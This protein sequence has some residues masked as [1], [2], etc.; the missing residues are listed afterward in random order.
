MGAALNLGLPQIG[1]GGAP[2]AGLYEAVSEEQAQAALEAAWDG[3]IRYF[4]TAPLY[5]YGLSE[6][7]L[8]RFLAGK[9]RA[10]YIVSTKAGRAL[11][12]RGQARDGDGSLAGFA[13]ALPY[14]AAFDFSADGVRRSIESSLER[15]G[16]SSIDIAF[17]HDPDDFMDE[18]IAHAIPALRRMRDEGIVRALGA[19]M[20]HC[21]PLERLV[22]ECDLD[23]ILA[24]G[25]YTLLD[26]SAAESLL[27]LCKERGV[28]V[29]A[30]GVFNSG[31]LAAPGDGARFD[32]APAPPEVVQRARR[33]QVICAKHNVSLTAAAITFPL[34]HPAVDC[35][36]VGMRSPQEVHANL[37]SA[38]E[39]IP[40]ALWD[41]LG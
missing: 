10:G 14:D 8:G 17:V 40:D 35:V 28:R 37:Q 41:D 16:V 24:A 34:R 25:R 38:R 18:A 29:V 31:I 12:P 21:A 1:F 32:Y 30:G 11:V 19:G 23:V 20:N 39:R 13:G 7:R 15:L 5:G 26:R 22:R 9:P 6:T 3:G 4:D 2:M 27:P 36:V 33:A